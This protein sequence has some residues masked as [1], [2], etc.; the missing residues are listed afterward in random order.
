MRYWRVWTRFGL[1]E[2]KSLEGNVRNTSSSQVSRLQIDA[3][4]GTRTSPI[5]VTFLL[6]R[7]ESTALTAVSE[8]WKVSRRFKCS[9]DITLGINYFFNWL[10]KLCSC[11]LHLFTPKRIAF[12]PRKSPRSNILHN[13]VPVIVSQLVTNSSVDFYFTNCTL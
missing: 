9:I 7:T 12:I 5:V 13:F 1:C 10:S 3:T 8:V 6:L 4:K 11:I 2:A